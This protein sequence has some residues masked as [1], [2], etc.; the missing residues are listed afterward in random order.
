VKHL[1]CQH[2]AN[3]VKGRRANFW[4]LSAPDGSERVLT[5]DDCYNSRTATATETT[6]IFFDALVTEMQLSQKQKRVN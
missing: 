4:L 5:C 3:P 2:L 1:V 6:K